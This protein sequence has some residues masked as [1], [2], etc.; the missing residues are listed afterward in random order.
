[1]LNYMVAR[2][3]YEE[4]VR[5]AERAALSPQI[6]K[7]SRLSTSLKSLLTLIARF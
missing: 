7:R 2:V 4:R 6:A 3:E 5:R 1:M